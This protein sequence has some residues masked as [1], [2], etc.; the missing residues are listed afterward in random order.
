MH[1]PD[2]SPD[3]V[4]LTTVLGDPDTSWRV[5]NECGLSLAIEGRW[6]EALTAFSDALREAPSFADAPDVHALLHGN[7]AQAHFHCGE[8]QCAVESAH[9]ALAARLVC[10]DADDAPVAR[11]RAD[12]GVY[13]AACGQRVEAEHSLRDARAS[14]EARFGEH[15]QRL[16]TVRENQARVQL[17][18]LREDASAVPRDATADAQQDPTAIPSDASAEEYELFPLP[19]DHEEFP[20]AFTEAGIDVGLEVGTEPPEL[21]SL[22]EDAFELLDADDFPPMRSPSADAIRSAGLVEPGAHAPPQEVLRRTNPLGFEI[23]YG[24]PQELLLEGDAA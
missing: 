13:L 11:I 8:L 20:D 16:A 23:Q 15:D 12:L 24:V 4:R 9:R 22:L 7:R 18:A 17:L 14:L 10:G 5:R 1:T 2:D 21:S 3:A 6:P 19:T